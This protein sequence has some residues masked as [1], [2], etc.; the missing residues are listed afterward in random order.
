FKTTV[1]VLKEVN[2]LKSD[3]IFVNQKLAVPKQ[4]AQRPKPETPKPDQP[5]DEVEEDS[6]KQSYTVVRGDTLSGMA[7]RFNTTVRN[8]KAVNKLTGD[9]IFVN[10]RLVVPVAEGE[11]KPG[12]EVEEK[13]T[14]RT[15]QSITVKRGDTLSQLA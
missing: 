5:Q 2:H 9:L 15:V 13:E 6:Q 4:A 14:E 11:E 8:L 12:E 3:L 1:Q 10:Q 7:Q